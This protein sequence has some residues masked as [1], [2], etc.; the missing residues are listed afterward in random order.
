MHGCS[1]W[2]NHLLQNEILIE[3][4]T[5]FVN[6]IHL[7]NNEILIEIHDCRCEWIHLLQNEILIEMH[8]CTCEWIHLLQNEILI[9][10]HDCSCE[11]IHG[12][13]YY[14]TRLWY[15]NCTTE[16][17][18]VNDCIELTTER[19]FDRNEMHLL[20]HDCEWIHLLQDEILI[21]MHDCSCEW[22]HLLQNE[23]LDWNA[24]LQLWM[25]SLNS[26]YRTRFW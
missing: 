11:W 8:G 24:R 26:Y 23:I 18:F 4:T 17:D 22:I 12:F 19:D 5:A 3:C 1:L 14:R 15:R 25:N 9:E 10:M 20:L 13:T 7:L 6:W 2:L 16:R 21:E